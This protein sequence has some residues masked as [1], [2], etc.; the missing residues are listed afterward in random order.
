MP[1]F[2][3]FA[4]IFR[5]A[6]GERNSSVKPN[7]RRW[8][9]VAYDQLTDELGPLSEEDPTDL[10]IV[11]VES[12]A[13][14][15]RR[16]YHKQKLA[17]VLG[18][19]RQFALEQAE[20]GVAVRYIATAGT[21]HDALTKQIDELGSVRMIAPAE[22]ELSVELHPL[23][24]AGKIEV[25]PHRGWLTRRADFEA[26]QTKP[27][28]PWRMD[29]FYREVRK[30][31]GILM[32]K[33]G[34]TLKPVGGKYSFDADNRK[35]WPGDPPA[36]SPLRFE[37]DPVTVEVLEF[38]EESFAEH[39]GTLIPHDLPTT[40]NDAEDLWAW[41]K[42]HC[43][44]NFG[45]YQDAMSDRSHTLFHSR[46]A[47]LLHLHRLLPKRVVAEAEQL[48]LPLSS[49]EG[50]IRQ[51]LGWREFVRH[52]HC[53]TE[54]FRYLPDGDA[55]V[56]ESP[57][58]GGYRKWSGSAFPATKTPKVDGGSLA[59][60]LGSDRPL[61]PVYWGTSSGLRCLD[62]VV[63]EVWDQAYGHHITRLM[64][65]SNL[66]TL[67]DLS[68]RE[69]TDWF[70]CAYTDAY[71]WVVE[72]NVL[73]MGTF[74]LGE[75]I[76]TKPYV[77]GSSYIHRMSDYCDK[78]A[79]HPKK[80][81]PITRLYWAFLNRHRDVLE[82]N[83]RLSLPLRNAQKRSTDEQRQDAETFNQVTAELAAG[84]RVSPPNP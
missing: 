26:S 39:P 58:D 37:P 34:R 30:R 56:D 61:P 7:E 45:P 23:I 44:A 1:A 41:A 47:P 53:A 28:G 3:S 84:N 2:D 59:S 27:G 60:F 76:T 68:P 24:V 70:W 66:A 21:Y 29:Q 14:G 74:A 5:A 57:G 67:L 51:I 10:G 12:R 8:L 31:T 75:L 71:E 49:K 43:L 46:I 20:R 4:P 17:Y 19:M 48:D 73:G 9:F 54:G 18:N 22:R 62:Q 72:P 52:V 25:E 42:E 40:R 80:T 36:P 50:F 55:S 69:L 15:Y 13:K 77:S 35:R 38:I 63:S 64:I 81:C 83:P 6:L 79:F 65:L 78:C 82:G 33:I 16:P 11:L 32:E